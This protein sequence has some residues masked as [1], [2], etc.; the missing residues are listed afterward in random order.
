M[1][2]PRVEFSCNVSLPACH[3]KHK[4][5]N[6]ACLRLKQIRYRY[7]GTPAKAHTF[8]NF[9]FSVIVQIGKPKNVQY[10][11]SSLAEAI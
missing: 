5:I 8:T 4:K 7:N 1:E 11:A 2:T 10:F 6:K 3:G 9:S